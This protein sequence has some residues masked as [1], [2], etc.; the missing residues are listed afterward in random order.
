M[1]VSVEVVIS[2]GN[3]LL[4]RGSR[5]AVAFIERVS[6]PIGGGGELDV[7]ERR[8]VYI[9]TVAGCAAEFNG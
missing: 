4:P 6:T 9:C 8:F 1:T 5:A 2:G 7:K 3:G